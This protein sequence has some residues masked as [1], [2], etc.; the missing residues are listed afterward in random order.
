VLSCC[1]LSLRTQQRRFQ[2]RLSA[3]IRDSLVGTAKRG[4]LAM[5]RR[6]T[7]V[8]QRPRAQCTA[9]R[10]VTALRKAL[11]AEP[12]LQGDGMEDA[13][14]SEWRSAATLTRQGHHR[15]ER[16]HHGRN[17]ARSERIA[18]TIS[19]IL[20][21]PQS[22]SQG[23]HHLLTHAVAIASLLLPGAAWRDRSEG[24][25]TK[26]REGYGSPDVLGC[27]GHGLDGRNR[28]HGR[29]SG[30]MDCLG[31]GSHAP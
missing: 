31:H 14:A 4:A 22:S 17:D 6:Q 13:E 5:S 21:P 23:P 7:A 11:P 18:G 28:S 12:A 15:S 25:G 26:R 10:L 20:C 1:A 9:D 8:E 16:S 2:R 30:M 27:V 24:G 3:G 29:H 19:V